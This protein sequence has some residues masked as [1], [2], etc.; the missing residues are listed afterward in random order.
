MLHLQQLQDHGPAERYFRC[1]RHLP[2]DAVCRVLSQYSDSWN[3]ML[4]CG[5]VG[6]HRERDAA[7]LP[8]SARAR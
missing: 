1:I 2:H 5:G 3:R 6:R 7:L 4:H 8:G